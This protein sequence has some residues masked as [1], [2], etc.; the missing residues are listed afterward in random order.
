M[1]GMFGKKVLKVRLFYAGLI[2]TYIFIYKEK[3]YE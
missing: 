2:K 1:L 3:Y